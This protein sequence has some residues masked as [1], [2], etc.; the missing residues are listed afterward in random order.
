MDDSSD[1]HE[2]V[3]ELKK[4]VAE[5]QQQLKVAKR[6][7]VKSV[8]RTSQKSLFGLPLLGAVRRGTSRSGELPTGQNCWA[9]YASR[10]SAALSQPGEDLR[11]GEIAILVGGEQPHSASWNC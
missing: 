6:R 9:D 2:E 3:A 7:P 5:L 4:T 10:C 1:L 8:R 11:Q